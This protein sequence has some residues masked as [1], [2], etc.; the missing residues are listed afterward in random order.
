MMTADEVAIAFTYQPPDPDQIARMKQL[1]DAFGEVA[2]LMCDLVPDCPRRGV[3]LEML[4]TANTKANSA[5]IVHEA[6]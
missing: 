5:I 3:A 4:Y 6:Q 2:E 1:R